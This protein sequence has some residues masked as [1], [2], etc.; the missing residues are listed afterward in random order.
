MTK[1][2]K[3]GLVILPAKGADIFVPDPYLSPRGHRNP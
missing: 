3:P 1:H 2:L